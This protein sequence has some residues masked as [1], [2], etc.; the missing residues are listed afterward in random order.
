MVR[1]EPLTSPAGLMEDMTIL[2]RLPP[3]RPTTLLVLPQALL[4]PRRTRYRPV[5]S[6][7]PRAFTPPQQCP[8]S[9]KTQSRTWG[10]PRQRRKRQ[11]LTRLSRRAYPFSRPTQNC[12]HPHRPK[13]LLP[14]DSPF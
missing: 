14:F 7:C 3:T 1:L 13:L 11:R 5:S 4:G 12:L 2:R 8:S 10:C 9:R 6:V